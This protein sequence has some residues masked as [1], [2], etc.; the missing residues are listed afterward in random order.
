MVLIAKTKIYGRLSLAKLDL[1]TPQRRRRPEPSPS[2]ATRR[3][4]LTTE[5]TDVGIA[6]TNANNVNLSSDGAFSAS[7]SGSRIPRL[8]E[9]VGPQV[10][11][12]TIFRCCRSAEPGGWARFGHV[13]PTTADL[14]GRP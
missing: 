10:F 8:V 12:T 7:K 11:S 6:T 13:E 9:L 3:P 1:L 14:P 2:T 4:S 5:E